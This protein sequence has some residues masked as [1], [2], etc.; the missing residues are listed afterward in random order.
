MQ[1]SFNGI[2]DTGLYDGV[3]SFVK[4][5]RR[6][7]FREFDE[8]VLKELRL[9]D[10]PSDGYLNEV[11]KVLDSILRALPH[12]EQVFSRPIIRLKDEHRIVPIEA[13]KVID[14]RSL[15]HVA[16]RCELWEDITENGIK[17]RKLMT[18]ENVETYSI[19]E[20]IVFAC[21]VDT[22]LSYIKQAAL[23]MKDVFYGCKDI[24]FNL[25]DKTHHSLYFLAIG[26]LYLE[27][28]RSGVSLERWARCMDKM[29]VIDKTLRRRLASPVYRKCKQKHYNIK[30]KKTNI[31][32]SHKDYKE[33]YKIMSLFKSGVEGDEDISLKTRGADEGFK[34]FCKLLSVFA[35]G[36]FNYS[37]DENRS[38]D[39]I[40]LNFD[41]S[42]YEWRLNV[43]EAR[44]NDID[45]VTFTTVKDKKYTTCVIFGAKELFKAADIEAFKQICAADEYLF[46]SSDTYGGDSLYL[47]I[48]DVDSFRRIQQILLR[49]MIYSDENQISCPFCGGLNE[50]MNGG[51]ICRSCHAEVSRHICPDTQKEYYVSSIMRNTASYEQDKR[52]A[53]RRKF[54]HDRYDEAQL[55]YRNITPIDDHGEPIC[56][57]CGKQHEND[58]V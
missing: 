41:C 15:T 17:P 5:K 55:H 43:R 57:H 38:I 30:L 50:K 6:L 3:G 47:S 19:Y 12:M 27:Y 46:C 51:Y 21:A 7:T 54:L 39:L 20:N 52:R 42:F 31:F 45:A 9:F 53:D 11:E 49:G 25:L 22:V 29:L 8:S 36:H 58:T 2:S 23:R 40:D 56:P 44:V 13:V 33:V 34:S 14:K 4:N 16:T 28:V 37:F 35:A 18:V 24:H 48:L 10:V 32:R 1:P 26:K